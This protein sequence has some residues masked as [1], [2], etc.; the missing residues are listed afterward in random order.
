MAYK[1]IEE[2]IHFFVPTVTFKPASSG[3]LRLS[4]CPFCGG[5]K[6]YINPNPDYNTFYCHSGNCNRSFG[7]KSFYCEIT[8]TSDKD[9]EYRKVA[10]L[11]DGK[12][13]YGVNYQPKTKKRFAPTPTKVEVPIARLSKRHEVYTAMLS[14]LALND[15][16]RK[17]LKRRGLTDEQIS[18]NGYKTAPI[19]RER[20]AIVKRLINDGHD[21]SGIPGFYMEN[22]RYMLIET[23]GYYIPY[24]TLNGRIQGLQVRARGGINLAISKSAKL[25]KDCITYSIQA[26]NK[27]DYSVMVAVSDYIPEG[28]IIIPELTTTNYDFNEESRQVS[29]KKSEYLKAGESKTYILTLKTDT[30]IFTE[31]SIGLATRFYWLSSGSKE[32][33]TG[34]GSYIHYVGELREVMYLT[35]GALKADV[36]YEL[37]DGR[38]SFLAVAGVNITSRL[39]QVFQYFKEQGVKQIAI[40]YDMDKVSN[41]R[42]RKAINKVKVIAVEVGIDVKECNWDI[43]LGKGI[44]DLM[45]NFKYSNIA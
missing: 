31:P 20:S 2:L 9:Y 16:D 4:E 18:N 35:E 42:V 41:W 13:S 25:N 40:A 36:A 11:L 26:T 39:H 12:D 6:A 38:R 3:N 44:D 1:S 10:D 34:S 32:K 33:G 23:N 37:C 14:Y 15:E 29:W 28:A 27:N 19:G 21:L 22:G 17:D 8:D 24:R 43:S 7:F 30:P 5:K 45:L